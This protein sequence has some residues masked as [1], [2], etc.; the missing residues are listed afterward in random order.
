MIL[1]NL[2]CVRVCVKASVYKGTK[3][4]SETPLD[5]ETRDSETARRIQK[6]HVGPCIKRLCIE[7]LRVKKGVCVGVGVCVC[8]SLCV[9]KRLFVNAFVS[10]ASLCKERRVRVK[11]S[12]C[13][14]ICV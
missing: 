13:K 7:R 4:D 3:T 2:V 8:K 12:V 11:A 9:W 6:L 10:K 1:S 5:S 14:Q